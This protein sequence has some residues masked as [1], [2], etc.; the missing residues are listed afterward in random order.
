MKKII[1]FS[2]LVL[3]SQTVN[4]KIWLV[5]N[6][7]TNP[8]ILHDAQIAVNDSANAGDTIMIEGS[9]IAYGSLTIAKPIT[10]YG[11]GYNDALGENVTFVQI[12][13]LSS[14]VSLSG[15]ICDLIF[16]NATNAINDSIYHV[17]I[18]RCFLHVG[19]FHGKDYTTG[20]FAYMGDI[21]IKN[22]IFKG[23]LV[24][25]ASWAFQYSTN[26]ESI[27]FDSVVFENN[28]FAFFRFNAANPLHSLGQNTIFIRNNLFIDGV[29]NNGWPNTTAFWFE[30]SGNALNDAIISNNIFYGSD[31]THC[32]NCTYMNNIAFNSVNGHDSLNAGNNNLIGDPIFVNYPGGAFD[33]SHDY[34][35]NTGSPCIGTG[36]GANDMGIYGGYYP[37]VTGEGPK[38]PVV[39]YVNI[40]NTAVPQNSTFYLQFDARI[41]K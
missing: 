35:L 39:D 6:N 3:L 11:E 2:L 13:I 29:P 4:A 15:V 17:S 26:Q 27:V 14:S 23:E 22:N 28:I 8:Q 18:E 25:G 20:T 31:A 7:S 34:H 36:V 21:H 38:I 9:T 19:R 10:I 30:F 24:G 33:Y 16:L 1:Y 12:E 32:D 40:S 37:F 41:R 5:D